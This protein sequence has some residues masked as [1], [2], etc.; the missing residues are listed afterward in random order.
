[1]THIAFFYIVLYYIPDKLRE[2]VW[3]DF[4]SKHSSQFIM[5]VIPTVVHVI[6]KAT[7]NF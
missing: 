2:G 6:I 5:I 3:E 7:L 4:L 1:M